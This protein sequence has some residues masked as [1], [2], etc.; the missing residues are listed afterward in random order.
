VVR[1]TLRANTVTLLQIRAQ[2]KV[3]T[4]TIDWV[5]MR[6][7]PLPGVQRRPLLQTGHQCRPQE[8]PASIAIEEPV[9]V[10][11]CW[12]STVCFGRCLGGSKGIEKLRQ[13][14]LM[15]AEPVRS[16]PQTSLKFVIFEGSSIQP[17][18]PC[19]VSQL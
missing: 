13:V 17:M 7:D 3:S 9:E 11:H 1:L 6:G 18:L 19:L 5:P 16:T 15:V 14:W 12:P 10:A 4:V 2:S 8:V